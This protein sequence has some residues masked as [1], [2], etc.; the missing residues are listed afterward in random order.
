MGARAMAQNATP[1]VWE[2]RVTRNGNWR[3]E[4]LART[5]SADHESKCGG[6]SLTLRGL[7]RMGD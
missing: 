6:E 1:A 5:G 4:M 7:G 3:I 2:S